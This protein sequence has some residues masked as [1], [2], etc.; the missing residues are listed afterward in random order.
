MFFDEKLVEMMDDDD[1]VLSLFM[2]SRRRFLSLS[3]FWCYDD[4]LSRS[5]LFNRNGS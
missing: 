5:I 3:L 4:V 2:V 1:D